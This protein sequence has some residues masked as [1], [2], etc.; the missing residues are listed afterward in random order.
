MHVIIMPCSYYARLA[1]A[2]QRSVDGFAIIMRCQH[3]DEVVDISA[4]IG[5]TPQAEKGC[6]HRKQVVRLQHGQIGV[7][8]P[9]IGHAGK[10][11]DPQPET[12]RLADMLAAN[13]NDAIWQAKGDDARFINAVALRLQD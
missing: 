4:Q 12:D 1:S 9:V 13:A 2:F 7:A 11:A 10:Q 3:T 6:A 5:I 8:L